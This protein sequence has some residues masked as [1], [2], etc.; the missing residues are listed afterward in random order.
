VN[1]CFLIRK[2]VIYCVFLTMLIELFFAVLVLL[3]YVKSLR[4]N[5]WS[6]PRHSYKFRKP[7]QTEILFKKKIC[8]RK[9]GHVVALLYVM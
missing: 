7:I 3:K 4:K 2:M 1:S 5:K 8:Q 9:G 6:K